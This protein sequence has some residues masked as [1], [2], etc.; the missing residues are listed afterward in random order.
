[1][2]WVSSRKKC[3]AWVLSSWNLLRLHVFL[4][5]VLLRWTVMVSLKW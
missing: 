4:Q 5:V 2:Q 3:V 1:M